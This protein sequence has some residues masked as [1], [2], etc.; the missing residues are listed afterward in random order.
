MRFNARI[1]VI[2]LPYKD[3]ELAV[4]KEIVI[5]YGHDDVYPNIYIVDEY[6][7]TKLWDITEG[8]RQSLQGGPGDDF[9]VEIDGAVPSG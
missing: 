6:D 2:P 7:R 5:A 1:P 9:T 8:I 3:K 4:E